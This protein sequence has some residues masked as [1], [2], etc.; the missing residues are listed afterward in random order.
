MTEPTLSNDARDNRLLAGFALLFALIAVSY[1]VITSQQ[2]PLAPKPATQTP[3]SQTA[4]HTTAE[5]PRAP[6][7]EELA[8]PHLAWAKRESG[9][10]LYQELIPIEDFFRDAKRNAPTFSKTA[11]SWSSKWR[12]M[13][14]YV[15]G[16]KG[17]RHENYLRDEFE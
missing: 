9:E 3:T 5:K 13:A 12:L 14:D 6:T 8:A 2:S 4:E 16:T 7:P 1:V 15:P 11:L 17:G 10:R